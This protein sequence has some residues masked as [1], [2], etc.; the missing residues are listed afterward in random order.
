MTPI[1][2]YIEQIKDLYGRLN[3]WLESDTRD[4]EE[5]R[6]QMSEVWE[7][8]TER[9]QEWASK[10]GIKYLTLCIDQMPQWSEN[11]G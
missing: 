10:W 11:D 9:Q 5:L 2:Q 3:V 6:K 4:T 1:E 8:L 7:Q